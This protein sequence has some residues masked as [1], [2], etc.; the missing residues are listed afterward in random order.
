[1]KGC[2][3][4]QETVARI[5]AVGH[6]NQVLKGLTFEPGA[7]CPP[8]G[9]NLEADGKRVGTIT[10]AAFARWRGQ[11]IALGMIRTSHAGGGTTLRVAE[12][13]ETTS[14]VAT[15]NNLPFPPRT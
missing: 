6:V 14:V 5:D 8:A 1:V 10:S 11:V 4:G 7:Q 13:G 3:L 12:S 15:V 2:Y 9:S